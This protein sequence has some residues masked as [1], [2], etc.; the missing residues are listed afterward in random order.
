MKT[1]LHIDSS[2]RRTDNEHPGHN[3]ISKQLGHLFVDTWM[4]LNH[5]GNVIH[6]DLGLNPPDFITQDWIAA[7][8]TPESERNTQQQALLRLSDVLIDELEQADLLLITAPMYNYGM[9]AVL[10]AW[11]DQVIRINKTFSFDLA[12]GDFPLAPLFRGKTLVLLTSSG[13][14]GFE[15]NGIRAHMN[16]LGPH[17]ETLSHYLGVDSVHKI[18]S[19]YQE[20]ADERHAQSLSQA[21]QSIVELAHQLAGHPSP[22]R[23]A[24]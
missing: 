11:F 10:K 1:L 20:F 22:E 8:F 18:R 21:R 9:P 19:E 23:S 4:N 15:P 2:V 17:I 14:F 12:R 16:H 24:T 7:V 5:Q 3:S 6:R 13:E